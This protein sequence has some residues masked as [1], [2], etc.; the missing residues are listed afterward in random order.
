LFDTVEHQVT[1]E[2]DTDDV[3]SVASSDSGY[4]GSVFHFKSQKKSMCI[5]SIINIGVGSSSL[6]DLDL[7]Q[8]TQWNVTP[9]N[10]CSMPSGLIKSKGQKGVSSEILLAIALHMPRCLLNRQESTSVQNVEKDG[11]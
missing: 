3:A 5:I 8:E 2:D 11:R 4:S 7:C 6:I 1:N 9:A 10:P